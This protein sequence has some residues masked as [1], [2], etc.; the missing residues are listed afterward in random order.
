MTLIDES[1]VLN[2]ARDNAPDETQELRAD[3]IVAP[4]TAAT[5]DRIRKER[6]GAVSQRTGFVSKKLLNAGF[7][8]ALVLALLCLI[9]SSFYLFQYLRSANTGITQLLDKVAV[10][11]IELETG[12][13]E[14]LINGRLVMG[15]LGL[16][17]AGVSAGLSFGFLGFALFLLGIRESM[18]VSFEHVNYK[19]NA[20]RMSPGVFLII[21]AAFLIGVCATRETPFNYSIEETK[22]AAPIGSPT[23]GGAPST[24]PT[25]TQLAPKIVSK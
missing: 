6:S 19:A 10:K 15:R 3:K 16:L 20:A 2:V 13:L 4:P 1:K 23:P 17:S 5:S 18:D 7:V 21:V 22:P 25:P 9:F 12:Q 14:V 8:F 24:S 11:Q